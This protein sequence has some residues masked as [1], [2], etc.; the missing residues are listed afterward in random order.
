MLTKVKDPLMMEKQAKVVY[1]IPCSCG[2]AYIG[3]TVRILETRVMEH[4]DACQKGAL[5]KSEHAW[6]NH[7]PM[8]KWEKVFVIDRARTA[9]ELLMKEAINIRLNRP[10][11]NRDA[12]LELP[13]CW[14]PALKDTR[15][16]PN[17]RPAAPT[18]SSS[19]ST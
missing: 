12:S 18:D 6:T 9:K 15:S 8:I 17:Q 3:E 11:L 13:R 2:E 1:R 4:R 7:H 16:G 14:M 10:S 19:D 5:E